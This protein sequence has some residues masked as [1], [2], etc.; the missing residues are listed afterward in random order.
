[1]GWFYWGGREIK[2]NAWNGG[3]RHRTRQYYAEHSWR[4]HFYMDCY[5]LVTETVGC[6]DLVTEANSSL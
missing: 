3:T 1:M 5:E 6:Y 2:S 4:P